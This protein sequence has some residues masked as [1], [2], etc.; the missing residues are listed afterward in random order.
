MLVVSIVCTAR[1]VSLVCATISINLVYYFQYH[2]LSFPPLCLYNIFGQ[3]VYGR[4]NCNS[5]A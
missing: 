5:Y 1:R 2:R 4:A 3:E